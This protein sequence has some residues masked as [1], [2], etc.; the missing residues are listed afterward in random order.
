MTFAK[1]EYEREGTGHGMYIE[2]IHTLHLKSG[3]ELKNNDIFKSHSLDKVKMKL[4]EVIANDQHYL[5]RHD[6]VKN[7]CE[8]EKR[9]VAW[10]SILKGKEWEGHERDIKIELP[11]GALTDSGVVFS[12]QPYE[13][14]CWAAGAYHFI[15][16]YKQLMSYMTLKAKRL[17][18][19]SKSK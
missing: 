1:Y 13:I 9:F 7:P 10:Q 11:N 5:A 14:D 6:S 4:F 18:G 15:V 2:M 19:T 3:K 17:I 16:P 12:F 8:I